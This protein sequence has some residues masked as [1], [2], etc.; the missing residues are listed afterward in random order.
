MKNFT[1]FFAI[2]LLSSS[3]CLAQSV[4]I[5][6]HEFTP[7]NCAALEILSVN[8]G[9]LIPRMTESQRE[10]IPNP[11][12]GLLVFQ[13]NNVLGFFFYNGTEWK[14]LSSLV[15]D[16]DNDPTNELQTL[17][18]VFDTIY[19]TNGGYAALP[20]IAPGTDEQQISFV[21]PNLSIERGNT[22]NL[23]TLNTDAQQL[24]F[25]SPSLSLTNGGSV[26][27]SAINTDNQELSV[28]GDALRITNSINHV[29]LSPYRDNT[30]SQELSF[31]SPTLSID[32]G[33]SVNLSSLSDNLGNH[34]ATQNLD[35]GL[36]WLSGTGEN[37]GIF[38]NE[39]NYLGI[40]REFERPLYPLHIY[41][42]EDTQLFIENNSETPTIV[43]LKMANY[44]YPD[45]DQKYMVFTDADDNVLGGVRGN[46]YR[47]AEFYS[48]SD[49][50]IKSNITQTSY[51]LSDIMKIKVFDYSIYDSKEKQTG[52]IAQELYEIIPSVVSVG[53][54]DP[55]KNPW[56]ISYGKFTPILTKS[57][58]ELNA[59]FESLEAENDTLRE[60]NKRLS[61]KVEKIEEYEIRLERLE[62]QLKQLVQFTAK[63]K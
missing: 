40:G 35:L 57:V 31:T 46:R 42:S 22:V 29:D 16:A 27:L 43:N 39:N 17:S 47:G 55:S 13:T 2:L 18:I 33:N 15:P 28:V 44:V 63:N 25:T 61:E 1:T 4:G 49:I 56:G 26:N 62:T 60:E 10:A 59:K 14:S 21:F 41:G 20:K 32:N 51:G 34:T 45:R 54:D 30:D 53:G 23:S 8:K 3:Y 5:G 24:S 36:H 58:Q 11:S 12:T 48:I 37:A 38:I 50:R 19:L 9:L 7:D 52:F 6:D